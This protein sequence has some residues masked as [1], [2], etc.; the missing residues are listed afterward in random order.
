MALGQGHLGK[1]YAEETSSPSQSCP[2]KIISLAKE[3]K[4]IVDDGKNL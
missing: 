3:K 4:V 2:K 1:S